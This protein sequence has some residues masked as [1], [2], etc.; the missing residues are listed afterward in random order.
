MLRSDIL[1][2]KAFKNK[3]L[4]YIFLVVSGLGGLP[5]ALAQNFP[6]KPVRFVIGPAPDLLPRLIAQK[7]S[8]NWGHQ[9]VVDQRPGA[10]GIVAGDLEQRIHERIRAL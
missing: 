8:E 6:A 7:L 9:V 10:G 5:F 2:H 3:Y 4:R 1:R